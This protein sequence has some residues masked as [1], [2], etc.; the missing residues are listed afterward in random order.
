MPKILVIPDIHTHF[1]KAE[2]IVNKYKDTHKFVFLGDYFDQFGDTPEINSSTAHWLKTTM[3]EHPDWVYLHGNHDVHYHSDYSVRC[4]GF[5]TAKKTAI[6]EVMSI[7]DWN[8]L[9]YFHYENGHYFSHAGITKYW[10][11]HPMKEKLCVENIQKI[12][13][14]AAYNLKI[15]NPQ[16][17]AIWAASDKRGGYSPVGSIT[18][19][20]WRDLELIPEIRQVVGHTPILRIITIS[21][22]TTKSSITN[23]DTSA[24]NVYMSELLEVDEKGKRTII[25]TSFL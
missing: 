15:H 19:Q 16:D 23:V 12:I 7:E 20:D 6:N 22:D 18:W 11:Q 1:S 17:N 2:R 10:F 25:N 13:D 14:D 21:D 3:N 4:S 8:K 5:S 9:K 24:S